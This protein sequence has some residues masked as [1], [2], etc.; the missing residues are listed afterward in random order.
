M[1]IFNLVLAGFVL[2]IAM[3]AN[4]MAQSMIEYN[5]TMVDLRDI[6]RVDPLQ[7]PGLEHYEDIMD[8]G[9]MDS[10][11]KVMGDVRNIVINQDGSIASIEAELDRMHMF[12]NLYLN[13]NDMDIRGANNA[14]VVGFS[15]DQIEAMV[16]ELMANI[17]SAA[18]PSGAFSAASLI[19]QRVTAE[20]GR[21][22]GA[23]D[24]ILFSEYGDRAEALYIAVKASGLRGRGVAVPFG[25]VRY[26]PMGN[27]TQVSVSKAQ[28]NAIIDT[29][30]QR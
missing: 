28:A 23:V 10:T 11:S 16:P 27:K 6:N 7:N 24:N 5:R 29:A 19:G 4:V 30:K 1:K 18:G 2:A 22:I 17:E 21:I 26:F 12:T 15:S 9:V 25:S 3:P 14:Y 8:R 13:F 20:D